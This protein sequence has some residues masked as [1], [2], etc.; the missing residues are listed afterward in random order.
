[1]GCLCLPHP[2]KAIINLVNQIAKMKGFVV[3]NN[4]RMQ[5]SLSVFVF[6]YRKFEKSELD[7]NNFKI[8]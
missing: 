7:M 8:N 2:N 3:S 6:V 4:I 5:N 1:M